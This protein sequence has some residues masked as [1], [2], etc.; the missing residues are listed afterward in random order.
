MENNKK[1]NTSMTNLLFF[2]P[3]GVQ[4]ALCCF[5]S[6]A[7]V[8][9]FIQFVFE[10]RQVCEPVWEDKGEL[11]RRVGHYLCWHISIPFAW[12]EAQRGRE[13]G[14]WVKKIGYR[15]EVLASSRCLSSFGNRLC[16]KT[17]SPCVYLLWGTLAGDIFTVQHFVVSY[18]SF[19]ASHFLSPVWSA[20]S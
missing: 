9:V 11:W 18:F 3:Q 17:K 13:K 2:S 1:T 8:Y 10:W 14:N 5:I 15:V 4:L 20:T 7:Y 16:I 19:E 6:L 12:K